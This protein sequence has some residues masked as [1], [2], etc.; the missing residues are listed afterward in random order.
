MPK[1]R[2]IA[3]RAGTRGTCSRREW[4]AATVTD[5]GNGVAQE[6]YDMTSSQESQRAGGGDWLEDAWEWMTGSTGRGSGEGESMGTSARR[7]L[8][9]RFDSIGWGL[10]FILCGA[11]AMPS[12]TT[13]YAIVAAV[14]ALMLGLNGARLLAGVPVRW[15]TIVLGGA[16]LV[17]GAGALGGVA[18]DAFVLFFVLLGVLT[19]GGALVRIAADGTPGRA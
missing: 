10:L 11:I 16:T 5:R 9:G 6:G 19:I 13:E 18:I 1:K 15:F 8:E 2:P 17:A 7:D 4:V 14:G 3:P 12:G